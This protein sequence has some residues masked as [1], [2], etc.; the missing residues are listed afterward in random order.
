MARLLLENARVYPMTS[1]APAPPSE[2]ILLDGARVVATGTA[3]DLAAALRAGD[4]RLDLA[5]ATVV[6]GL[7]DAHVHLSWYSFNLSQV[8]LEG[9]ADLTE[10][11]VRVAEQNRRLPPGTWMEGWGF[12]AN[13]WTRWPNRT[14]LDQVCAE[15]PVILHGKDGHTAWVNSRALALA[16]INRHTPDPPGGQIVRDTTGEPSG[17]LQE[18]AIGLV[19]RVIPPRTEAETAA[20]LRQGMRAAHAV[21]CT[22]VHDVDGSGSL[23]A[24]QYLRSQGEL[25]LRVV[26]YLQEGTL[27]PAIAAGIRTGLGDGWIRIGGIKMFSDG[28][29]GSQTAWMLDDWYGR[30]GYRG[31]PTHTPAEL[32]E[33]VG[34]CVRHGL[35]C[36]IHA[37]GDAANRMVL[38]AYTT[39][40]GES[41]Q[42]RLRHRIEHAQ[43]LS[44]ADIARFAALGVVASVQPSHIL[45]DRDPADR[46][47][48]PARSRYT[49]AFHS[50]AEA[51]S[52]LAC[53]SDA[54][55]EALGPLAGL[56][57]AVYRRSPGGTED[58]WYPQEA[59]TPYAAL[60][61]FTAGAAWAGGM[62]QVHGALGPDLAADLAVLSHDPLDGVEEH[63]LACRVLA[64]VLDGK[65]IHGQ[66]PE[67]R[68]V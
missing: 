47:L 54:P 3:A 52:R 53:G 59:L 37:I 19:R 66:L 44:P 29:L 64:T 55:V 63:L 56:H 34:R 38:D 20:A 18:N 12:N 4:R 30:P 6:P 5:G 57:A 10:G 16:D 1:F 62:E 25:S 23:A 50:L 14:D 36:A 40:A 31:I 24:L 32:Q 26:E 42:R 45:N 2:A 68:R 58:P 15:R 39:H 8:N 7:I 51:G 33:L 48:G 28:A 61:G 35:A 11:L 17:L 41:R 60:Y 67:A 46:H 21:G 65:V 13:R 22:G 9:T 27:E 49:Y 43:H